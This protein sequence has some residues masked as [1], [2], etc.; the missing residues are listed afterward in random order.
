MRD[1]NETLEF[2]DNIDEKYPSDYNVRHLPTPKK[3]PEMK[4]KLFRK[5]CLK[6]LNN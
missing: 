3:L 1:K 6:T 5:L 4:Q 2:R